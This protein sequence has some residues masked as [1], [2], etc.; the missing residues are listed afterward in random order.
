MNTT[1]QALREVW[2]VAD[3]SGFDH[4]WI[5]DHLLPLTTSATGWYR[6][7]VSDPIFES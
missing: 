7:E 3:Q 2:E 4:L 6:A 1:A 5:F